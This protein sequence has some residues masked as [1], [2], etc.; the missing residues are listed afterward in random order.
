MRLTLQVALLGVLRERSD[1][2]SKK[3]L[4][5]AA[6]G[7]ARL[8]RGQPMGQMW[9]LFSSVAEAMLDRNM[10]FNKAR[11]R[12]L[13]RVEKYARE[14]VYVGRVATAKDAPDSLIRDLIY[15]LYRSGSGNPEV[16]EVLSAWQVAPS[17]FPDS[18]LETHSRR[19]YG[20]GS[21]VLKSLSEA[22]QEEL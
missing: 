11:K 14:V 13:M 20:P 6:R 1:V 21:D 5:R 18:L 9:C 2:V 8:C 7:F 3:L 10:G 22:L 12:T 4:S 15:I 17:D 16:A 19:L